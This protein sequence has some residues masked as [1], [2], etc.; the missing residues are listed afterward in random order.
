[1]ERTLD[2]VLARHAIEAIVFGYA[3]AVDSGELERLVS[4]LGRCEVIMPDGESLAGGRAVAD[5]YAR[6]IQFY[7]RDG[8]VVEYGSTPCSPLTKHVTSNLQFDFDNPVT[9]AD[10]RSYFTVYQG[11]PAG[12]AIVAGGRY[13][14]RFERSL[15]GWQIVRREIHVDHQGDMRNHVRSARADHP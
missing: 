6:I 13:L 10:V 14:D 12:N 15:H 1:M 11:G 7:D 5:H 9:R 3:E 2:T 8:H 4:L